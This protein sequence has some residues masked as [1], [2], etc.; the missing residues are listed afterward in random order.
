MPVFTMSEEQRLFSRSSGFSGADI[1]AVIHMP[2]VSLERPS[3]SDYTDTSEGVAYQLGAIQTLS[4]SVFTNKE[5]VRSL[6]FRMPLDYARGGRTIA[7]S[8]IFNQLH[9]HPL[10]DRGA[11]TIIDNELGGV[12]SYSSGNITYVRQ[13]DVSI[14]LSSGINSEVYRPEVQKRHMYDFSWDQRT[15]GRKI[16]PGDMPKFDII[17]LFVNE[18]GNIGKV[19][20]YGIDLVHESSVLS[21]NDIYTEVTYQYVAQDIEYFYADNLDQARSWLSS[22]I[23]ATP[24]LITNQVVNEEMSDSINR[25]RERER[26]MDR[27]VRTAN[28]E[29]APFIQRNQQ[30]DLNYLA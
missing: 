25:V 18:L 8:M 21:I 5:A 15:M 16:H 1:S 20:L 28:E 24:R 3:T 19:I 13:D 30:N 29:K 7:G 6:G 10:D 22:T 12:L 27:R 17:C 9:T 2:G 4:Y 23:L 14:E 26:R 11:A